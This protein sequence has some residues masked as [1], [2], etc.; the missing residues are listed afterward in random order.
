MKSRHCALPLL[1]L[2]LVSCATLS[3]PL[4]RG[5]KAKD[6]GLIGA[7]EGPA[8]QNGSLYFTDGKRINRLDESGS[9]TVFRNAADAHSANGLM[10]DAEGR[11][12]ARRER[13]ERSCFR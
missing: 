6:H 4:P 1:A 7:G 12:V 2:T 10:F 3:S 11:L 9:T 8:W 13:R 5:V